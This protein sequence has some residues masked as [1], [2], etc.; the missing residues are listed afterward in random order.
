MSDSDEEIK[1]EIQIEAENVKHYHL[2]I[3]QKELVKVPRGI[4]INRSKVGRNKTV[5]KMFICNE[6]L[7]R[8]LPQYRNCELL[9][10]EPDSLLIYDDNDDNYEECYKEIPKKFIKGK[11]EQLLEKDYQNFLEYQYE[12]SKINLSIFEYNNVTYINS[13][14]FQKIEIMPFKRILFDLHFIFIDV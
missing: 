5:D 13:F 4:S 14:E 2:L 6:K 7:T 12:Y 10:I 8:Y 3:F 11:T 9:S 1:T